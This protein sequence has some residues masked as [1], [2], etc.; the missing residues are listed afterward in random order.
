MTMKNDDLISGWKDIATYMDKSVRTVQR[1]AAT[2]GMPVFHPAGLRCTP[3]A[4]K[5]LLNTWI[6]ACGD[7][8]GGDFAKTVNG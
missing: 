5:R 6:T 1:W 2:R 8:G 4:S 7:S 3:H